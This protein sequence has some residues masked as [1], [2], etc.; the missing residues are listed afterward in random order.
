MTRSTTIALEA[1]KHVG[2]TF[3]AGL[4][5]LACLSAFDG[6]GMWMQCR[7]EA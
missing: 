7:R 2:M 6:I 1:A 4:F 5:I 3:A